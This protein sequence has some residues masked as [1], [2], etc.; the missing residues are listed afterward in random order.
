MNKIKKWWKEYWLEEYEL[1]I[2]VPGDVVIHA[3]GSRTES[4]KQVKYAA[5]KLIKTVPKHFVFVDMNGRKNEIKFLNP[6]DFH[7]IKVW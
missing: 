5:K 1:I 2:S 7:V 3:D 6:V 4:T